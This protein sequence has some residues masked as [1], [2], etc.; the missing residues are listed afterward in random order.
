MS[1]HA[2]AD[3]KYAAAL[4]LHERA[5]SLCRTVLKIE[6]STN[7]HCILHV[8]AFLHSIVEYLTDNLPTIDKIIQQNHKQQ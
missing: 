1:H 8:N 3:R 7:Y 4:S 5:P 6:P 2:S